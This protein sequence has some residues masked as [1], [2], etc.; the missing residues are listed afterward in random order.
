MTRLL[1]RLQFTYPDDDAPKI[2]L[3]G[4]ANIN[5]DDDATWFDAR[6]DESA[7]AAVN[8]YLKLGPARPPLMVHHDCRYLSGKGESASAVRLFPLTEGRRHYI[9]TLFRRRADPAVWR[10]CIQSLD[11]A[12]Y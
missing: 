6:L 4:I 9:K 5:G 8:E 12:G 3:D 2:V 1:N 11:K 7:E 10:L